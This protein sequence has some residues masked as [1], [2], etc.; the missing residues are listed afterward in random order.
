MAAG[1]QETGP[2]PVLQ[3]AVGA[4][5][6]VFLPEAPPQLTAESRIEAVASGKTRPTTQSR[7]DEGIHMK[8]R[9]G[10]MAKHRTT[11]VTATITT[12][13]PAIDLGIPPPDPSTDY[14]TVANRT[15]E[16]LKVTDSAGG[17]YTLL[18]N[19]ANAQY[20]NEGADQATLWAQNYHF[21]QIEVVS[22]HGHV[23]T[24]FLTY[25][26]DFKWGSGPSSPVAPRWLIEVFWA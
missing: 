11:A 6:R 23:L 5:K 19:I 15:G 13:V 25:Q 7:S 1:T 20:A 17:P 2:L 24:A 16:N 22:P 26:P 9:G 8:H 3:Q 21:G 14:I 4:G 12:P 18:C 10:Q